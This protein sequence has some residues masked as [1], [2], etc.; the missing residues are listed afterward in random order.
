MLFYDQ[1]FGMFQKQ[2]GI[3]LKR[4]IPKKAKLSILDRSLGKIDCIPHLDKLCHGAVITYY[5]EQVRS[6][7]HIGNIELIDVP[8]ALARINIRFLHQTLV[9]CYYFIPPGIVV[10]QVFDLVMFLYT[11]KNN[12]CTKQFQL[13]FVCKLFAVLGFVPPIFKEDQYIVD[14]ILT[15]SIDRL[16]NEPLDLRIEQLLSEWINTCIALHPRA[17]LLKSM[18]VFNQDGIL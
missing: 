3:V 15:T 12:D 8:F 18:M 17:Q 4:F 13:L 6:V 9:V 10:W 16:L 5:I 11:M 14:W 1:E 7:Y 2:Y